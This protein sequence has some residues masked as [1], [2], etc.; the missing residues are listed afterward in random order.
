MA[1]KFKLPKLGENIDSGDV[2][3]VLVRV[4]D[5]ISQ[6][7]PL[8]ELETEKAVIEVPCS[9]QGI[10]EEVHVREGDSIKPGQLIVTVKESHGKATGKET[11]KTEFSQG[12]KTNKSS[13]SKEKQSPKVKKLSTPKRGKSDN[14]PQTVGLEAVD[15]APVPSKSTTENSAKLISAAPSV[16]R[17]ARQIGLDIENIQGSGPQGRISIDDVKDHS[18]TTQENVK[19]V[20]GVVEM[21]IESLPDFTKWGTVQR[22]PL[23][24]VRQKMA[25]RV[26][27]SWK[28]VPQVTQHEK[29]D[30]TELEQARKRYKNRVEIA[31]G[32]LTVTAIIVK[33]VASALNVFPKF[34]SSIDLLNKEI[35]YKDYCHIGVAVDTDRG[36]LVPVI[37]DVDQKNITDLSVELF[38]IAERARDSKMTLDEME[39]GSFTISNLGGIGGTYFSPIVNAPEVAILGVSQ[40]SIEPVDQ[41]GEVRSRLMIPLSL[42]YDHRLIDGAEAIRFL[43]WIAQALEDPFLISLEG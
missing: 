42:S 31:G 17:F 28:T 29:A 2:V 13:P 3:K 5:Q 32:K 39:G 33:I 26:I 4:G 12:E 40:G 38:E 1:L 34:K 41:G 35:I 25:E 6:E 21:E 27:H 30:I 8:L 7:Q 9:I 14:Q 15:F 43:R 19:E 24:N 37:R 36:L 22:K 20:S 10:V 18:R 11:N 23:G 16:R